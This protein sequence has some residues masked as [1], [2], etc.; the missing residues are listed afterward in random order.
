VTRRKSTRIT[1][2]GRRGL[3]ERELFLGAL[4]TRGGQRAAK[5]AIRHYLDRGRVAAYE[6]RAVFRCSE[7][8]AVGENDAQPTPQCGCAGRS[9]R[10]VGV[11]IRLELRDR[12]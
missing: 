8:G 3:V 10:S 5:A 9:L 2:R 12:R 4:N 11:V 7:C 6:L 1:V